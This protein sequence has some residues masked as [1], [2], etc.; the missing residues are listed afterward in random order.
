MSISEAPRPWVEA[1]VA[2]GG[3]RLRW[4]LLEWVDDVLECRSVRGV[5]AVRLG[6]QPVHHRVPLLRAPAAPARPQAATRARKRALI[7]Q[8]QAL[9]DRRALPVHAHAG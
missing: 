5:Q 8:A 1:P 3:T 6:G 9:V 7:A 2:A 4:A